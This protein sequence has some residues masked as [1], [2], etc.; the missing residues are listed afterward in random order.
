MSLATELLTRRTAFK[1]K[2]YPQTP[3]NRAREE[4]NDRNGALIRQAYNWRLA[5]FAEFLIVVILA[6]GLLYQ[7]SHSSIQPYLIEH[8]AQSGEAIGLGALP[9][10][11]YTP[12]ERE[13]RY[14]L[15]AWLQRVRA[16]SMD[17]VVVKRNWLEAY[18]FTT[19]GAANELNEWA[20]KDE[21][22]SRIG[23]ET[24]SIE[25]VSINP[26][27]ESHSYQ[28]RWTETVRTR[29][30]ELKEERHMTGIFPVKLEPPRSRDEEDLRVNPL[31]IRIDAGFQWSKDA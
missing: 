27:A 20:Q 5:F 16:V 31:G 10:W 24:V 26:I 1:P 21:R 4:W 11:H 23:E 9:A 17:P 25:I 6:A 29:A 28:M 3:H 14:F 7:S 2:A 18:R 13:Y 19:Q 12:Q 15:G 22:L 8:N 30:G